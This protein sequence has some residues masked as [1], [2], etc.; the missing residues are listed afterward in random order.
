MMTIAG[1]T[2]NVIRLLTV[3]GVVSTIAIPG[4]PIGVSTIGTRRIDYFLEYPILLLPF[5]LGDP[6]LPS[7]NDYSGFL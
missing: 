2:L 3:T 4:T 1:A 6:P 5:L 7:K